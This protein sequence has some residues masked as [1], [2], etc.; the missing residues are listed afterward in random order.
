MLSSALAF[1]LGMTGPVLAANTSLTVSDEVFGNN[2]NSRSVA[3]ALD[4]AWIAGLIAGSTRPNLFAGG[5]GNSGSA[6]FT[7]AEGADFQVDWQL[8]HIDASGPGLPTST[9]FVSATSGSST[10][11]TSNTIQ[12]GAPNPFN[13]ETRL[14]T[15]NSGSGLNGIRFD[16]TNSPTNILEFGLFIGD[17]EA[18]ANNGTDA[19]VILFDE[20]GGVIGDHPLRY[21]G[22]VGGSGTSYTSIEP[23]GSPSGTPNNDPG[24]WGDRTTAF[25]SIESDTPIGYAIVHV[26]DDDHTTN[27]NGVQEQLGLAGFQ[28]PTTFVAPTPFPCNGKLYQVANSP[29]I[30]KSLNFTASGSG[31]NASFTDI[32]QFTTQINAGWGYNEQ[33]DLLYGVRNGTRELW[34]I[35]FAGKFRFIT[36]LDTS[37]AS[38]SNAGDILPDGTMVYKRSNTRWQI[39]DISSPYAPVNLGEIT[40]STAVNVVDFSYS[41]TDQKI[42]GVDRTTGRL[43]WVDVSGGAGNATV[44]FF[45]PSTY[46]GSYGAMWFDEEG[47]LYLYDNGTNEISV[48]NVG[49]DGNGTGNS[50]VLAVSSNDEG[51]I[52]DGAY[53]RGPAPVPLGA[54]SGTIYEDLDGSDIRETGEPGIGA[55]IAVSLYYDNGTPLDDSD[56]RFIGT[57]DTQADGTYLFEGLVTIETYRVEVDATDPDLPPG[58]TVGTTNPLTNI[59]VDP[60]ATTTGQDF[61]FDPGIADL[62]LTKTANVTTAEAG[63]TVVWTL[64]ITNDGTGAPTGVTVLDLIPDGFDYVSDDAVATGDTYDPG[65]GIWFV[66]EILVGATEVLEITTLARATGDGTNY[67][68]IIASSLEDPDSDFEVG[69]LVDDLD[70]GLPD[71]DEASFAVALGP[72][73]AVLSGILFD[74]NGA[75]GAVAHDAQLGGTETGAPLGSVVLFDGAGVE[76]ATL[77]VA[78]D[79]TWSHTLPSDFIGAVRIVMTAQEDWRPISEQT[80]GLPALT[81]ADPHDG[82]FTFE[83]IAGVSYDALNIGL[84][85]IPTLE[86]DRIAAISAG[87]VVELAHRYE[88]TSAGTVTFALT[89][90]V[91]VPD[92]S[93]TTTMFSDAACD[94]TPDAP[95]VAPLV[96]TA[97]QSVCIVARTQASGGIGAGSQVSYGLTAMTALDDTT[98]ALMTRNDDRLDVSGGEDTL[99]LQKLVRNVTANT[100]E[101]TSNTGGVGDVLEYRIVLS[102][103][104][105]APTNDVTVNDATPAWTALST[106]VTLTT[107]IAPGIVCTLA[108]P[109]AGNNITGYAG[110]LEW[111]CPGAFPAGA[112][113]SLSFQ[114]SITP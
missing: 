45:G 33:D 60:N 73:G 52:N 96:V 3:A 28:I 97:G 104:G 26:G 102:N 79:G 71:D 67:A 91:S 49:V 32:A 110:P 106:P 93:F 101:A 69:R 10:Y 99:V 75:G 76:I 13:G 6:I 11:G 107:A 61:G 40:L 30:L 58:S 56:D 4:D 59:V 23:A 18:R 82:T 15:G 92:N 14:S 85:A 46:T 35:D 78:A 109:D 8:G 47:R 87:A 19:R 95:L 88:A 65:S 62:S 41:P 50:V 111:S 39:A 68:E 31:Y 21:T 44:N 17:L 114:V 9:T 53:C 29:S 22:A 63:D 48:V 105:T 112:N 24:D 54:L 74:D 108:V 51:G 37:F 16:F 103:P 113:G 25:I 12:S 64:S 100:P 86:A 34:R 70:D 98:V 27:N 7:D 43:F 5:S 90:I 94:G 57:T 55:G 38:G 20:L 81:N 66:G 36:T 72:S 80:A 42:Y 84:V 77:D 83:P 1:S 2:A 89:D